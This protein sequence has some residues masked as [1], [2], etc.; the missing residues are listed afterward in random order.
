M[1]IH[2]KPPLEFEVTIGPNCLYGASYRHGRVGVTS[3][4]PGIGK[5]SLVLAEAL[6]MAS[7]KPLLGMQPPGKFRVWFHASDETEAAVRRR[8]DALAKRHDIA[9]SYEVRVA[10]GMVPV[11][12]QIE[13]LIVD[14]RLDCFI[15]DVNYGV[16]WDSLANIAEATD[17]A[18]HVIA[19]EPNGIDQART[20]RRPT[21]YEARAAGIADVERGRHFTTDNAIYRIEP[22]DGIGVVVAHGCPAFCLDDDRR[23]RVFAFLGDRPWR[24]DRQSSQWLGFEIA[25]ELGL[26]ATNVVIARQIE[27]AIGEWHRAGIL[28]SYNGTDNHRHQCT[29]LR[30]APCGT[31]RR[32]K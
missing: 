18:I 13:R 27:R 6:A 17:C 11:M 4:P 23:D 3:G 31:T 2:L 16:S 8:L 25:R 1:Y 7:G 12:R 22:M 29:Y 9:A 30:P 24:A 26:D 14:E 28:E 21:R 20:L 10:D 32:V 19:N 15:I 5:T